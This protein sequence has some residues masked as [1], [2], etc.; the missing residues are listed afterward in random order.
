MKADTYVVG[1]D[2]NLILA[3]T[4]AEA[5]M[6][7]TETVPG[8]ATG[9]VDAITGVLPGTHTPLPTH[10]TLTKIPHIRDHLH[11]EVLQI[12]LE[13][14]AYHDPNQH[15]NQPRRPHTK[16]HQDPG[17]PMIIHTLRGTPESQ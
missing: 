3:D 11:T 13:T 10:I 8:H 15:T 6:T 1:P 12:T 4:I 2:H 16:T 5:T 17:N 14:A 9:T 7:P